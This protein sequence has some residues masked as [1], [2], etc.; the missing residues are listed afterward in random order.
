[1]RIALLMPMR[2]EPA[3]PTRYAL[4]HYTDGLDVAYVPVRGLALEAARNR[5]WELGSQVRPVPD[6]VLWADADA[7]WLRGTLAAAV[8]RVRGLGEKAVVGSFH[9]KR[10]GFSPLQAYRFEG[11]KPAAVTVAQAR[12][13]PDGLTDVFFVGSH[14][15]A[16]APA[17]FGLLGRE[18]F[19]IDERVIGEDH[20]FCLRAL[21]A[22]CRVVLDARLPVFH[23]EGDSA[24]LPGFPRLEYRDGALFPTDETPQ[25]VEVPPLRAY[26][27]VVDELRARL[28]QEVNAP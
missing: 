12:S 23:C 21:E 15:F 13:A 3:E 10:Y 14:F 20:A 25:T 5:L 1:M 8:A 11:G 2:D 26:G 6:V 27:P 4:E 9:G 22:G 19:A 18:P 17:L 24:F 28:S 7:F 16:H